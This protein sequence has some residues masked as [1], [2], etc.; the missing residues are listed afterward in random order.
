MSCNVSA[1]TL[2]DRNFTYFVEEAI[3]TSGTSP[4]QLCVELTETV[5]L[6]DTERARD[7][8]CELHMLGAKVALDDFGT[9]YT[10][11]A[12]LNCLPI[13]RIKIDRSFIKNITT[14]RRDQ[15]IVKGMVEISKA[16]EAELLGEGVEVRAQAETL[17]NMGFTHAQGYLYA[18]PLPAAAFSALLRV[19]KKKTAIA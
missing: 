17:R 1:K 10:S 9:G 13:S 2:V 3:A 18:K 8:L 19:H 4:A 6:E 12:L 7:I 15:Q 5:M 11:I 16:L 14:N